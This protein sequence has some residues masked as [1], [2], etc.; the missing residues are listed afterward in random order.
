VKWNQNCLIQLNI[1]RFESNLRIIGLLFRIMIL[2]VEVI[3]LPL[4]SNLIFEIKH[5]SF[6]LLKIDLTFQMQLRIWY[7]FFHQ[8]THTVQIFQ[9]ICDLLLSCFS[10]WFSFNITWIWINNMQKLKITGIFFHGFSWI[11]R[12]LPPWISQNQGENIKHSTKS[13]EKCQ[14]L[15]QLSYWV[16]CW[17]EP[18]TCK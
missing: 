8:S 6:I 3:L 4:N 12:P 17:K 13:K 15:Y 11:R 9:V 18:Q 5:C 7:L 14:A 16:A 1:I 10:S 2:E